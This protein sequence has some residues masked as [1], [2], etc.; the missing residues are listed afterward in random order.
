MAAF[1]RIINIKLNVLKLFTLLRIFSDL[2][3]FA[4][5]QIDMSILYFHAREPNHVPKCK[6][7]SASWNIEHNIN[8][9]KVNIKNII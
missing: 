1:S 9:F 6:D 7:I 3:D 5:K 4:N 8:H 2:I